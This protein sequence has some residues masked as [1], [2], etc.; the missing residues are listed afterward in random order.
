[1][2]SLFSGNASARSKDCSK[3]CPLAS[4]EVS[5]PMRVQPRSRKYRTS[6]MPSARVA[7][8]AEKMYD[9]AAGLIPGDVQYSVGPFFSTSGPIAEHGAVR[10]E[11][12]KIGTLFAMMALASCTAIWGLD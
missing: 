3:A 4:L 10:S 5:K 1:V 9:P 11:P 12:I 2:T 8:L 7:A 6:A